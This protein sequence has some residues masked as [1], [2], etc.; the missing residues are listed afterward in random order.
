[1]C[2]HKKWAVPPEVYMLKSA[3][4]HRQSAELQWCISY[5]Y[6]QLCTPRH[7]QLQNLTLSQF[8]PP[9]AAWPVGESR[10]KNIF[11]QHLLKPRTSTATEL[12]INT[13]SIKLGLH[14]F[15]QM[16]HFSLM[17]MSVNEF[18]ETWAN[19]FIWQRKSR[20]T[21]E[22]A[23]AERDLQARACVHVLGLAETWN[24]YCQLKTLFPHIKLSPL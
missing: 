23:S 6:K 4:S 9:H 21:A 11:L 8:T 17:E 22:P 16:V 15:T 13:L 24:G 14:W 20:K 2:S 1:M 7:E 19:V 10:N 5:D 12:H 18:Q 3:V